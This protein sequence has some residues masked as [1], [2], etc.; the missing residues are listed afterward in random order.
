MEVIVYGELL[1]EQARQEVV[2]DLRDAGYTQVVKR[3]DHV[4]YRHPDVWRGEVHIY[5][6]GWYRK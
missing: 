5:D 2:E 6:D 4:I 1:V 3:D